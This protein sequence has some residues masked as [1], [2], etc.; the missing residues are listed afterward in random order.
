MIDE[1]L[2]SAIVRDGPKKVPYCWPLNESKY[3]MNK[4]KLDNSTNLGA[5]YSGDIYDYGGM[6]LDTHNYYNIGDTVVYEPD[7]DSDQRSHIVEPGKCLIIVH[8]YK[9]AIIM[10]PVWRK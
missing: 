10:Q 7:N 9:D 6:P 1:E 2:I 5:F 8:I 4:L 3:L